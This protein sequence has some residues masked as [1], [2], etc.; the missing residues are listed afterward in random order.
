MLRASKTNVAPSTPRRADRVSFRRETIGANPNGHYRH[1]AS[2]GRAR[3][4]T[5]YPALCVLLL[6]WKVAP[7]WSVGELRAC[8][9]QRPQRSALRWPWRKARHRLWRSPTQL[10][11]LS[12]LLP[13][14]KR[15]WKTRR[16]GRA[17]LHAEEEMRCK[18]LHH[19]R[20]A[21]YHM[22]RRP[23]ITP[24]SVR[25]LLPRPTR[26]PRAHAFQLQ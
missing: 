25:G 12:H 10:V 16:T 24:S 26:S 15:V 18:V 21:A 20:R 9:R 11:G 6:T 13:S 23:A 2:R 22:E 4:G 1:C 8:K 3:D 7:R 14:C 19:H 17:Y 5:L